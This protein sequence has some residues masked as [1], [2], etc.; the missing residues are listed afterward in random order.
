[1]TKN[2]FFKSFNYV[3]I[4]QKKVTCI[5]TYILKVGKYKTVIKIVLKTTAA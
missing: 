2:N 5:F 4:K 1:M 3:Q